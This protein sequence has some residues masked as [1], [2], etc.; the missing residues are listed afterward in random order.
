MSSLRVSFLKYSLWVRGF[1]KLGGSAIIAL[2]RKLLLLVVV[3]KVKVVGGT[4]VCT[5]LA[6]SLGGVIP[7]RPASSRCTC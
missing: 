2:G 4:S 7:G 6:S 5:Y 1:P 3:R